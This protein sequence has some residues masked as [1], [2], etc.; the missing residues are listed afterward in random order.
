MRIVATVMVAVTL[1][2]SLAPAEEP[3]N[4]KDNKAAPLTTDWLE[5]R[6]K[7][8]YLDEEVWFGKDGKGSFDTFHVGDG[9]FY[10]LSV[11]FEYVIDPKTNVVKMTQGKAEIWN[12][13][14]NHG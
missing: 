2:L 3:K 8:P 12:R 6:W 4:E 1:S 5:G 9:T 14:A 11:P 10:V 7:S 13:R